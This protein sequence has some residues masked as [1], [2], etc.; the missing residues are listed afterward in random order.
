MTPFNNSVRCANTKFKQGLRREWREPKVSVW[1]VLFAPDAE[2]QIRVNYYFDNGQSALSIHLYFKCT[3]HIVIVLWFPS[4]QRNIWKIKKKKKKRV[5]CF[6]LS[7]TFLIFSWF[8]IY[9]SEQT[10]WIGRK[11]STGWWRSRELNTSFSRSFASAP[12]HLVVAFEE[13]E[14]NT[15][16]MENGRRVGAHACRCLLHHILHVCA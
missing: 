11:V 6:F 12:N 5:K 7:S 3:I 2:N 15:E 13:E 4:N 10:S 9:R 8:W 1:L 14:K 16:M